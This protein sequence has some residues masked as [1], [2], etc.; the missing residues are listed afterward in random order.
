MELE[1]L[2]SLM[3]LKELKRL[4][5]FKADVAPRGR[6]TARLS[7]F[8]LKDENDINAKSLGR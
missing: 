8:Q 4:K 5:E 2:R 7:E 3:E 1:E 6:W